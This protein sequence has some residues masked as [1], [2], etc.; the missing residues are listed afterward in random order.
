MCGFQS[1]S[2]EVAFHLSH[3]YSLYVLSHPFTCLNW[4]FSVSFV[5]C[6]GCA[7]GT[8]AALLVFTLGTSVR[9]L[10]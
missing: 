4:L 10:A 1:A 8:S 3:Q 9:I 6:A 7:G 5:T 2:S